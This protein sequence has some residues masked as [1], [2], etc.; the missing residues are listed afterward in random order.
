MR[1]DPPAELVELLARL[2]LADAAAIRAAHSRA[3]QLAGSMPLLASVWVDALAQARAITPFQAAEINAGRGE[4]LAVGPYR[5]MQHPRRLGYVDC[6]RARQVETGRIVD[7]HVANAEPNSAEGQGLLEQ[8]P[9][10][11]SAVE[12]P[13]IL[14][15]ESAGQ[16][17]GR[18]WIAYAPLAAEPLADWLARNGRLPVGAAAEVAR[19]MAAALAALE[20]AGVP[21]G[22]ISAAAVSVGVG[23]AVQI[24]RAGLRAIW[25]PHESLLDACLP[26]SAYDYLSPERAAGDAPTTPADIYACGLLCWHALTGRPPLAG[27]DGRAKLLA[28]QA[29]KI[30]DVRTLAPDTPSWL[31]EAIDRC[32]Q[33]D[34]ADRPA[35]FADLAEQMSPSPNRAERRLL[36]RTAV[37]SPAPARRRRLP[38]GSG[39]RRWTWIATVAGTV[40]AVMFACFAW[41]SHETASQNG[42]VGEPSRLMTTGRDGE[43]SRGARHSPSEVR[44]AEF[45]A[46]DPADRNPIAPLI[47][48]TDHPLVCRGAAWADV[49]RGQTVRGAAQG[50]PLLLVPPSGLS[51]TA[52]N[53]RFENVDFWWLQSPEAVADP[54]QLAIIE[55]RTARADFVG[56]TFQA[57]T[58][59]SIG[60]P[61]AIRWTGPG[62]QSALAHSG[63]LLLER[64]VTRGV[65]AGIEW[66]LP[67][68]AALQI[69]DS[70]HLGPGPLL[71]L[72]R[73]PRADETTAIA[74]NH[75]T[76]RG[77]GA[78]AEVHDTVSLDAV[79]G[80]SVGPLQ[81][82]TV[83]CAFAPRAG[84]ALLWAAAP[85]ATH[86]VRGIEWSGQGSV[87]TAGST[88]AVRSHAG[89]VEPLAETELAIDGLTTSRVEFAG[90][91]DAGPAASRL[92]RW[93]APLASTDPPGIGD[94][95]PPLPPAPNLDR[96][97]FDSRLP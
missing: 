32:K 90:T 84:G 93:Q 88:V 27:G 39:E 72:P 13:A 19:Q 83:D 68:P 12:H 54:D 38:G 63:R 28:A 58:L 64:C 76:L 36:A 6:Y 35:S 43:V 21:H 47:L 62:G 78:V 94:D 4:Q 40:A 65:A 87:L 8:L 49:E 44:P 30:D 95:L 91:V 22:D 1:E 77:A 50:R 18:C 31:A 51:L 85:D 80:D 66:R 67:A 37:S 81:L 86:C 41:P 3:R 60:R 53:V 97:R 46:T 26:P 57:L 29:G 34:P 24:T 45:L 56:C 82:S 73:L 89:R 92:V 75:V 10:L 23:G 70:L 71:Y 20:Q 42:L 69:H 25:R 11:L 74:L 96:P 2:Q 15:A 59:G 79:P 52:D 48:P 55:L 9:E 17:H 14:R 5:L 7:L 61:V 16:S 33:R